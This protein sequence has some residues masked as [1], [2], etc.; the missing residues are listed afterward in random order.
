MRTLYLK[1]SLSG[2]Y[3]QL[4]HYLFIAF[5][6][7]ACSLVVAYLLSTILQKTISDPIIALE[8]T[9]K[10]ISTGAEKRSLRDSRPRRP[11]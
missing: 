9:A 7:I 1:S 8:A 5:L 11:R 6:L 4:R 10:A 2:M 3:V